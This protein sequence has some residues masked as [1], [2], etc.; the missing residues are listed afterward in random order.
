MTPHEPPVSGGFPFA[1]M[2]WAVRV[3]LCP[4]PCRILTALCAFCLWGAIPILPSAFAPC[5]GTVGR[6]ASVFC[7]GGSA[8]FW[9]P[10]RP[11]PWFRSD[12][13]AVLRR[14]LCRFQHSHGRFS[15]WPFACHSRCESRMVFARKS[16]IVAKPCINPGKSLPSFRKVLNSR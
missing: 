9:W 15:A 2:A 7:R 5:W 11:A 4:V 1:R 16:L 14:L 12:F 6:C 10:S 3:S 8:A 13:R